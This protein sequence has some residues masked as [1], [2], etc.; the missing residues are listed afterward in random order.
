ME[1]AA[2]YFQ[3]EKVD[4]GFISKNGRVIR[5]NDQDDILAAKKGGPIERMLDGNSAIMRN[6][7]GI[8]SQQLSVLESIREGIVA[9]AEGSVSISD[10]SGDNQSNNTP[11]N[12]S[13]DT[14][15]QQYYA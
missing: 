6:I 3:K 8:N 2:R 11:L 15:T 13:P 7:A 1:F 9:I 12:F 5:F 4:D 14:L 10:S